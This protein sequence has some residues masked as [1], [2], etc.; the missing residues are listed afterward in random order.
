MLEAVAIVPSQ[1]DLWLL[2]ALAPE[3]MAGLEECLSSGMLTS[4]A[5]SVAFRHELARLAVEEAV[6]PDRR[7]AL[8]RRALA[9]RG[10]SRA[11]TPDLARLGHH[12]EAAG[13]ADA[14]LRFAPAAAERA[15]SLGAHREAAAQYG[16]ALRFGDRL[17]EGE[18]AELLERR[19][20]ECLPTDQYDEGIAALEEAL[21][22]RRALGDTLKQGDD[23]RRLSEFLWCPGR[24][25]E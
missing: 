20:G 14:V 6:A 23:L 21:E 17:S 11:A 24:T 22:C 25:A 16:R 10:D 7:V 13:D 1:A 2:E 8:H 15:A 9:A 19:A 18:R 5:A 3:A 4:D 12:A